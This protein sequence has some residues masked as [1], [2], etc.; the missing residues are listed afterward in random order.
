M[1]IGYILP[2]Y[3]TFKR[4]INDKETN[5][6][7]L[8]DKLVMVGSDYIKLTPF[9]LS[10]FIYVFMENLPLIST[11]L[12]LIE[13]IVLVFLAV[14][15]TYEIGYLINDNVSSKREGK[16][17]KNRLGEFLTI[18]ELIFSLLIRVAFSVII[19]YIIKV[20]F[21]SLYVITLIKLLITLLVLFSVYNMVTPRYRALILFFPLR[22]IK[23]ISYFYSVLIIPNITINEIILYS[24]VLAIN[25]LIVYVLRKIPDEEIRLQA[26]IYEIFLQLFGLTLTISLPMIIFHYV[27]IV[28]VV[29]LNTILLSYTLISILFK[30]G[31]SNNE[32]NS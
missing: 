3:Y 16:K 24:V 17:G 4:Y 15:S 6:K 26:H 19:L 32:H 14:Q 11:T 8:I 25:G 18:Y 29:I 28:F 12:K 20:V 7:N 10:V 9:Y 13:S 1:N 31:V 30:R 22:F 2:I 21:G 5:D 23:N 27:S